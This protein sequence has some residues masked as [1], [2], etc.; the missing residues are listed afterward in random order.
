MIRD[1]DVHVRLGRVRDRGRGSAHRAKPFIAGAGG[2]RE[3]RWTAVSILPSQPQRCFRLWP[4][5]KHRGRATDDGSD[6]QRCRQ[7]AHRTAPGQGSDTRDS[8]G[9]SAAEGVT[10]DGA[11]ARLFDPEHEDADYCAMVGRMRKLE[12]LGLA[13]R[14][15][16]PDGI[17]RK[18]PSL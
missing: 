11:P 9:L 7:R 8:L 18:M 12:R 3:G 5:G 10:K 15:V 6:A 4:G 17:Y 1:D 2:S 14:S 16:Q 13:E